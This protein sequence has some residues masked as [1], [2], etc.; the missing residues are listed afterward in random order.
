MAEAQGNNQLAGV[1]VIISGPSGVGKTTI[2]RELERQ[3][4]GEFSVS[5]TT[6]P[7]TKADREGVDY[8]FVNKQEFERVRDGG[9][10]LEWARV[11][12][13]EYGTP[14][15]PVERA[16]E[17]GRL[18]ILEIDVQGAVQVKEA[19]K[20]A[21]ALF[22]LPPSEA[23][24]LERLRGRKRDDEQVIQRRFAKAQDE[25]AKAKA[26]GVY[27]VFLVN[28]DLGRAI[29]ESVEL[30]RGRLNARGVGA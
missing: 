26:S 12:D 29:G 2:A 4:G 24:L 13:H 21:F 3:L 7:K 19:I 17:E 16:M 6:R 27:D 30:V 22:I 15:E 23:S 1:L 8:F 14:R 11:F 10:L 9:G 25:I 18:M 28:E 5:M 20:E